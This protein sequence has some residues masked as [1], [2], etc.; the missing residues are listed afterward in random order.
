M[1]SAV[2]V[3]IQAIPDGSSELTVGS[4]A[5]QLGAYPRATSESDFLSQPLAA[6]ALQILNMDTGS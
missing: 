5:G 2:S 3:F 4:G 6:L 1:G